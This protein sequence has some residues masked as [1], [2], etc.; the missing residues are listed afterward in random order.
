MVVQDQ[1]PENKRLREFLFKIAL[2][3][4]NHYNTPSLYE[5]TT[6]IKKARHI[7]IPDGSALGYLVLHKGLEFMYK[8][9]ELIAPEPHSY[10][11]TFNTDL[12]EIADT[13]RIPP[14]VDLNKNYV[15][16]LH[17]NGDNI[18]VDMGELDDST[19]DRI[20]DETCYR[21]SPFG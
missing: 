17:L 20:I 21:P 2:V 10:V 19:K 18:E 14:K 16:L 1:D 15:I 3:Y 12:S 5:C 6:K 7:I 8:T 11:V 13:I 9:T 4:A